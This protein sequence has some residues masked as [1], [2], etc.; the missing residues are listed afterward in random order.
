MWMPGNDQYTRMRVVQ[1][2]T[3]AD[4]EAAAERIRPFLAPTPLV[5]GLKLELLQPTGSF[6]VRGA[7]NALLQ[8][9]G[10]PVVTASAG[11]FGLAVAWAAGKLG[12]EATVVVAESASPAKIEALRR[13]P[14]NLVVHGRDY[15]E[16]ER[17]GLALPGRYVSPYN[18]TDVIA[19]QGTIAFELPDD[20]AAIVAP[21]G[22]G[23]LA[24]G[25][26]LATDARLVGVV[27]ANFPAMPAALAA[28]RVVEIEGE[29]TVADALHGNIEPGSVTVDLLRGI[30]IVEV[31]EAE[32]ETAMRVLAHEHGLVTE[33]AGATAVAAQLAGKAPAGVAIVTGRNVTAETFARVLSE[34]GAGG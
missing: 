13:L 21:V 17:H 26:R 29:W 20:V 16:A 25:L 5:E 9:D 19:G 34:G 10:E 27:P 7:L 15:D 11:N 2:P 22:G 6:K 28:G 12:V 1:A 18:D 3:R 24:A 33:G 14:V 30:E 32:I 4:V 23:G 8:L 31:T